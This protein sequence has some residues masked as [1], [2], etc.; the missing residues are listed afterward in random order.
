MEEITI[1]DVMEIIR[2]NAY[3]LINLSGNADRFATVSSEKPA[4]L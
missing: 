1:Q 2:K 4:A 3:R